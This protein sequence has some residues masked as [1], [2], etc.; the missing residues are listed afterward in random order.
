LRDTEPPNKI[1][2]GKKREDS[3]KKKPRTDGGKMRFSGLLK[4]IEKNT[5]F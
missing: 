4:E 2:N 3:D 1:D 5:L